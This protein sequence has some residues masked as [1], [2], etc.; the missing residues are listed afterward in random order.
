MLT[1]GPRTG[2]ST[3]DHGSGRVEPTLAPSDAVSLER[4][5]R[6]AADE[7]D[8]LVSELEPALNAHQRRLLHQLRLAAESLGAIRVATLVRGGR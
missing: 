7:V 1:D 5:Q 8:Q 6:V 3:D 2:T 4:A